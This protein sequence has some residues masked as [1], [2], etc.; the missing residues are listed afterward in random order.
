MKRLARRLVGLF[1][2]HP[3][4]FLGRVKGVIHVGANIGQE[5]D[6]YASR[7]LN[8]LWIEPIPV[9]FGRLKDRIEPYPDQRAV[10]R[11]VTDVDGKEYSFHL[12]SNDGAS[13]SIYNLAD[14]RK[15]WPEVTFTET[16]KLESIT[17]ASLVERE[18]ID[19]DRYDALILDTQ[20]SE[21]LVL[22]GAATLLHRFAFIKTEAADFES[23]EGCCRLADIDDF[24]KD[25][26]FKRTATKRVAHKAGVGSYYE[27][28]YERRS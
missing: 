17:L 8:V 11:L 22:K 27:V 5:R 14:H 23:Y 2:R 6:I 3:E 20:G 1:K 26:G 13:S 4:Y 9:V 10:N 28:S 25:R 24:L 7:G 16:V 18:R 15:I 19:L 12:S 21:L